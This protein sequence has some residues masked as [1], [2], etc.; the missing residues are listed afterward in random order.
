MSCYT[1]GTHHGLSPKRC[2]AWPLKNLYDKVGHYKEVIKH[3]EKKCNTAE[4]KAA[5]EFNAG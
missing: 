3:M 1:D 4:A 2:R 5:V